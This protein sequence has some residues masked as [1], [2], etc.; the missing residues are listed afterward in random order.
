MNNLFKTKLIKKITLVFF[1]FLLSLCL[2]F[3]RQTNTTHTNQKMYVI[4]SFTETYEDGYIQNLSILLSASDVPNYEACSWEII[5]HCRQNDFSNIQFSYDVIGYPC[6]LQG[7]VYLNETD[8]NN[9]K[10]LFH[11]S[12]QPVQYPDYSYDIYHDSEQYQLIID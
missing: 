6:V 10:E 9:Q 11:F 1:V 12:Y 7:S 3:V 8:Y 2:F 5:K 4:R